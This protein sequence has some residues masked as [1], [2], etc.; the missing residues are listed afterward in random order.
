M[1]RFSKF[2]GCDRI[3]CVNTWHMNTWHIFD[4]GKM[5]NCKVISNDDTI[6][7][8]IETNNSLLTGLPSILSCKNTSDENIVNKIITNFHTIVEHRRLIIEDFL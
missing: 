2:E 5:Y 7:I 4:A 8:N 1:N 3:L 6:S